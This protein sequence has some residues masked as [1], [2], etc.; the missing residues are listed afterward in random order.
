[1][2]PNSKN[3]KAARAENTCHGGN[4]MALSAKTGL[5]PERII[6]FSASINPLGPPEYLRK[7][8]SRSV[9]QII[10]YPDPHGHGLLSVLASTLA[11]DTSQLLVANG[12]TEII[13]A[14]PRALDCTRAVIPVPSYL[15]YER[16]C[17][18]A[19]LETVQV[20][21]TEEKGFQVNFS[22][23]AGLL[24][25][26]D[27]VFLGRPNNPTGVSFAAV[28]L[29]QMVA[30][31]PDTWFAVD[32]SFIEFIDGTC[33]LMSRKMAPNLIVFRSLTKFYAIPG[34]RLGFAAAESK[35]A[36][37]LKNHLLPWTVNTI[38]QAAGKELL[39]DKQ[40]GELTRSYVRKR[41]VELQRM[42]ARINGLKV[43]PGEANFLLVKLEKSALTAEQMADRLLLSSPYPIAIRNCDNFAGLDHCFFRVAVRRKKENELLCQL[44][45]RELEAAGSTIR[46]YSRKTPAI[47]L[48]GTSSNAGKSVLTAALGR[49]FLQDG[50][51]VAPF[52][53]QN[54]SLNSF[55]TRDGGEMGRA[56]VVQAQACRLDPDVRMNPVLLKPSSDIG[57][58]VIVNGRVVGNMSVSDY[59]SFKPQ[60]KEAAFSAYDS[61]AAEHEV[62]VLEGAGS[63]AEVNLKSHD[64]VNMTMA[65]YA[66][67]PVVLVGDIDRGG[68]FASF[69]GTMEVMAEWERHLVAGFLVNRFRGQASLL[70]D[71]Y[72]YVFEFTG[73]PVLGTIPYI[74]EHGL[75]EEDSVSFKAGFYEKVRPDEVHVT[76]AVI[77]LPHISNFTDVEPFLAEPDVHLRI[78]RNDAELAAALPEMSALI[79]PGSKN[80][81]AD[82]AYLRQSG[83][84]RRIGQMSIQGNLEVVGICGG[85]QMLGRKIEDPF[86]IESDGEE[87]E[88][89]GVL[90]MTT[91]LAE[92]KTL[93]RQRALHLPSR[94][95]VHGYEIHHGLTTAACKKVLRMENGSED[96]AVSVNNRAWGTYLHGIFDEDTFRRWF[97]DKLRI[98]KNIE[99]LN[100]VVAPYDLEPAFDRLAD[101]VRN[102]MDIEKLYTIMGL[103]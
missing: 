56:Q 100:R 44:L 65:R 48:Q 67:A 77:D 71:A 49:I 70:T 21:L 6:D 8:I 12:S 27:L 80:V 98:G 43:F 78:I 60:A 29:L 42:L 103:K 15:D 28:D 35:T 2:S 36:A 22:Q 96:G 9:E 38:A 16:A 93:A 95:K 14:L 19:G 102:S 30:D 64:I 85:F 32:E 73:K 74:K 101:I 20:P 86:R 33:E 87:I 72:K 53:A 61:L 51:R 58:Q 1:M 94:L 34:L 5:P 84:A 47:M 26:R 90:E 75:P 66:E 11:V 62:I 82:L 81:I 3:Q 55:V 54:M 10:H 88:G 69:V 13:Y 39:V 37:M 99:P 52:K 50:F 17:R 23:L 7:V 91:T 31:H 45:A 76:I 97:I 25:P 24:R 18:M 40:F 68:V 89:L 59:I 79:L 57:S 83:L 46:R 41:R 4:L 63:P 92:E